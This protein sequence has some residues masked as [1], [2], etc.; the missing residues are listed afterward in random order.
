MKKQVYFIFFF[1]VLG[2]TTTAQTID[3]IKFEGT[4]GEKG[5]ILFIGKEYQVKLNPYLITNVLN[6]LDSN[7]DPKIGIKL[8]LSGCT[9]DSLFFEN[10]IGIP[11]MVIQS[12]DNI[13]SQTIL[14][15][16]VIATN[17][18]IIGVINYSMWLKF[19]DYKFT[20][21]ASSPF[22]LIS[23]ILAVKMPNQN[24]K[25]YMNRHYIKAY[26]YRN[27]ET[28]KVYSYNTG[29]QKNIFE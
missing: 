8:K 26:S 22:A 15:S 20:L 1:L 3:Y 18:A 27:K 16:I 13:K 10:R 7:Y 21:A 2:L 12:L 6:M 5:F 28:N 19:N 25:F 29:K 11:I 14:H 4:N 24:S 23:I 17:F 9:K